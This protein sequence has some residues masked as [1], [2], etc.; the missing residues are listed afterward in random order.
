MAKKTQRTVTFKCASASEAARIY[1]VAQFLKDKPEERMTQMS[2]S[3]KLGA[4]VQL[5]N[6]QQSRVKKAIKAALRGQLKKF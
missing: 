1:L 6:E 3:E 5:V 2:I 4:T